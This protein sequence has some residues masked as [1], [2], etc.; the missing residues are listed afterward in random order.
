MYFTM[1]YMNN[2]NHINDTAY[3]HSV[4]NQLSRK[5]TMYTNNAQNHVLHVNHTHNHNIHNNRE[6]N[7]GNYKLLWNIDDLMDTMNS[8]EKKGAFKIVSEINKQLWRFL[9]EENRTFHKYELLQFMNELT[10]D[11]MLSSLSNNTMDEMNKNVNTNI[12]INS[13]LNTDKTVNYKN[14]IG[15]II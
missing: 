11:I 15:Y 7:S 8:D 5:I 4:A 12:N 10:E 14:D 9:F 3:I 1:S 6:Y 13:Q 2:M